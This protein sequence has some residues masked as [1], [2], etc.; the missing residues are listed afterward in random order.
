M[1][2][3]RNRAPFTGF[4]ADMKE[5]R[6]ALGFSQKALAEAVGIDPRY[7]ANI[8]NSG[9]LPSLPVF[10][11]IVSLCRLPVERYFY[12]ETEAARESKERERAALKLSV[13]PERYLPIVEGAI[14]AAIKL[15]EA[16][17][18]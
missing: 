8:E 2:R 18:V 9:A 6:K 10:Y 3:E 15:D 7:L 4:G 11:E 12:P 17:Q 16:G 1:P 14:D 13:C 5:A